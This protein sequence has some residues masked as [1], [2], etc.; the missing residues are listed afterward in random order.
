MCAVPDEPEDES[1]E[2]LLDEA[3]KAVDRRKPHDELSDNDWHIN[4]VRTA[5]TRGGD[6][7]YAPVTR[8]MHTSDGYSR[9]R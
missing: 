6:K 8:L 5:V 4:S 9:P 1:D 3:N 7:C 2:M